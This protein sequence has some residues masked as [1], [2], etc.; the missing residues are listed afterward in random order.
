[1]IE[2]SEV[3][4]RALDY[5]TKSLETTEEDEILNKSIPLF[6]DSVDESILEIKQIKKL[7]SSETSS[8]SDWIYKKI[9]FIQ[10]ILKY[11]K[12]ELTEDLE[13]LENSNENFDKIQLLQE[14]IDKVDDIMQ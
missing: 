12:R 5:C 7:L 6:K 2:N 4:F 3:V 13:E 10:S 14:E 8:D 1:M 11:Y 9:G